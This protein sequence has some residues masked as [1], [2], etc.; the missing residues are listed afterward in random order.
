MVK[1]SACVITKNEEMHIEHWLRSMR[2][3]TKD[4]IVVDTGS[5]DRT[6][7]LAKAGGA[8]V[9]HFEWIDD[10]AAAKNYAIERATGDWI[11]FLDA[12]EYFTE[13]S[14]PNVRK[15]LERNHRNPKIEV[16]VCKM[17]DIDTDRDNVLLDE[18]YNVRIFRNVPWLRYENRV[19]EM[20]R[21]SNGKIDLTVA[22]EGIE[23]LHTGYTQSIITKKLER[24]LAILQQDIAQEGE[25]PKHYRFL[26]DCYYG[27]DQY[28]LALKYAKLHIASEWQSIGRDN[29]MQKRV[30]D[31]LD[32]MQ[33]G[34]D[35]V[36]AEIDAQIAAYPDDPEFLWYKAEY[37]AR[38]G[39]HAQAELYFAKMFALREGQADD[40]D[41]SRFEARKVRVFARLAKISER[42]GDFAA[43][44]ASCRQAV[45]RQKYHE[46]LFL[47]WYSWLRQMDPV[48][49]IGAL[50]EVYDDT[51]RDLLFVYRLLQ[52]FPESKVHIY[53]RKLLQ[54]KL[55]MQAV[56]SAA[57]DLFGAGQ[58]GKAAAV[59]GKVVTEEYARLL[60]CA[61]MDKSGKN[62]A[63][64]RLLLPEPQ[65]HVLCAL[66]GEPAALTPE[67]MKLYKSVENHR[68]ACFGELKQPIEALRARYKSYKHALEREKAAGTAE[69]ANAAELLA[70]ISP[71][72][73]PMHILALDCGM[74]LLARLKTLCPQAE[75]EKKSVEE[76]AQ[77]KGEIY[78]WI[79]LGQPLNAYRQPMRLLNGLYGLLRDGSLLFTVENALYWKCLKQL[80]QKQTSS[81]KAVQQGAASFTAAD[82]MRC[83]R[84]TKFSDVAI[85]AEETE[86]DSEAAALLEKLQR[87]G[88]L[89][90]AR[91]FYTQR[92]H[93]RASKMDAAVYALQSVLSPEVRRELVFLLRRVEN[94]IDARENMGEL[95][96][97]CREKTV[98]A[99]YL[100][101]LIDNS[102]IHKTKL[103][104]QLSSFFLEQNKL[105]TAIRLLVAALKKHAQE[106]E[107]V[108]ALALL[109]QLSGAR[110]EAL[111]VLEQFQG[112]DANVEALRK[113]LMT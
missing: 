65:Q 30:I 70:F 102:M 44:E 48:E 46:G 36:M 92:W 39:Q 24:N 28:E 91:D 110:Q 69:E 21:K 13:A 104:L 97:L 64:M 38:L 89:T 58:Y 103:L 55:D 34:E 109:L 95:L 66:R 100:A 25:Q 78:H 62:E 105:Q 22:P 74:E 41:I 7:E 99:P 18:F 61:S 73:Q 50:R 3:I 72:T 11:L 17:I 31:C 19:H 77:E 85:E 35:V 40:L 49:A 26:S 88:F 84:A 86:P 23:I 32:L 63:E 94:E 16:F 53:Y 4:L 106:A 9:Y 14:L 81:L 10:F 27:L 71:S 12:D 101:A 107:F 75:I 37:L 8:K 79:V 33:A 56:T 113:E 43:A 111:K 15:L 80:L 59:L 20:L 45:R 87:V 47:N 96:R 54:E 29:T 112:E 68:A 5:T 42:K 93:V 2:R 98:E 82:L 52:V 6:V 51:E 57:A 108:C 67:E 76:L 83:L 60:L 1:I 90:E